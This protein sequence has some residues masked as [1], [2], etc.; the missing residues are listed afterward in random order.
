MSV[1]RELE[2][3]DF[4]KKRIEC[5]SKEV[6]EGINEIISYATLKRIPAKLTSENLLITR[7]QGKS[8]RYLISPAFE[9]FQPIDS[10]KYFQK[11]Y[12]FKT[13]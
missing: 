5:S 12:S 4:V 9:L 1:N 13:K 2:I 8:I 11:F 6:F 10:E 7:G 3:T